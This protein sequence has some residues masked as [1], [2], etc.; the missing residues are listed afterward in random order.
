[1]L[2]RRKQTVG[3]TCRIGNTNLTSRACRRNNRHASLDCDTPEIYYSALAHRADRLWS[4][5]RR[6]CPIMRFQL[7][8][9]R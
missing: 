7:L 2:I 3:L 5:Y 6:E 9:R 1:M 4:G 8:L